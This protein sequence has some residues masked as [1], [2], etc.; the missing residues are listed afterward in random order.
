[1]SKPRVV[2]VTGARSVPGIEWEAI[3]FDVLDNIAEHG[4]APY[5]TVVH[6]MCPHPGFTEGRW[7]ASVDMLADEWALENGVNVLRFPALW[8]SG[9]KGAGPRRNRLMVNT[10]RGM[11]ESGW[12]VSV[13]A[14]HPDLTSSK[15]TQ[16]CVQYAK[17][18]GLPVNLHDGERIRILGLGS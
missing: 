11:L 5:M 17:A 14:F 18:K 8:E 3:V 4:R 1:M 7:R 2:L 10:V 12:E 13:D 9:G 15:G 16:N 6:G